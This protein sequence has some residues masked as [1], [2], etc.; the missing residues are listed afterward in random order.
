MDFK[1]IFEN[2]KLAGMKYPIVECE[3][4]TKTPFEGVTQ[5]FEFLNKADYVK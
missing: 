4:Y 3:E 2:T 1:T 5:S